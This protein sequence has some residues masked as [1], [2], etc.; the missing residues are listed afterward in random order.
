MSDFFTYYIDDSRMV[1]MYDF[2]SETYSMSSEI[3]N[4]KSGFFITKGYTATNDGLK[5]FA[6]DL[7]I[8]SEEIRNSE[9]FKG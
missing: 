3:P 5:Q 6:Q 2:R 4:D 1:K 7:Y 9:S 8:Q